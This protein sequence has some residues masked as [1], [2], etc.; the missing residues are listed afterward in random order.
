MKNIIYTFLLIFCSITVAQAGGDPIKKFYRK[1]KKKD[2]V[3][4][5]ALPGILTR[6]GVGIARMFTKDEE[7]KAGLKLAKKMKGIRMLVDNGQQV[8][9]A[10]GKLLIQELVQQGELET[11]ISSRENG[12]HM[13][14]MGQ[15]KGDKV[16]KIVVVTFAEDHFT[17]VAAKSRLRIKDV[18]Q[19]IKV[20]EHQNNKENTENDY[21]NNPKPPVT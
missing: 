13:V 19:L 6:T 18:N 4:N 5:I 16:K 20:M 3:F 8:P 2:E 9:K 10:E 7:A 12:N 1:Y 17:M 15:L 21:E 11:L 14:I